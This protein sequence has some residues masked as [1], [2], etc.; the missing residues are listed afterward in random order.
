ME[1]IEKAIEA[2]YQAHIASL[3]KAL[4]QSILTANG[5]L[6]EIAAAESRFKKGLDFAADIRDRARKAA[7]V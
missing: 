6:N 5:D 7:E 4:S 2:A 3:Y 1:V